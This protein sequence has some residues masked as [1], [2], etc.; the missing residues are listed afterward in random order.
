[1]HRHANG[2]LYSKSFPA[3]TDDPSGWNIL[4]PAIC[5][6]SQACAILAEGYLL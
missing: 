5:L 2:A 6:E 1:M 4:A 3:S